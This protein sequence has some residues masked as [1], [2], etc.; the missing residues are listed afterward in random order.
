M[1]F[2]AN[3]SMLDKRGMCRRSWI[4]LHRMPVM[5]TLKQSCHLVDINDIPTYQQLMVWIPG[6]NTSK[7]AY[8]IT[9]AYRF[10]S[11]AF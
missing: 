4:Q 6:K 3:I 11:F 1:P 7:M 5:H 9:P 2:Y 8:T 10:G